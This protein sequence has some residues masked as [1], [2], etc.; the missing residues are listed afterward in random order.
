LII[1]RPFDQRATLSAEQTSPATMSVESGI[2]S[3]RAAS[4][5]GGK[6][7]CVTSVSDIKPASA[8]PLR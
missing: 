1:R 7:A 5:A 8:S 3:G 6:V 4:S 2:D